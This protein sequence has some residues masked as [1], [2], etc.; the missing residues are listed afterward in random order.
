MFILNPSSTHNDTLS[1]AP[2][3]PLLIHRRSHARYECLQTS[4]RHLF[5]EANR[6]LT[7]ISIYLAISYGSRA[8]E[9]LFSTCT[10][11]SSMREEQT[12]PSGRKPQLTR[13]SRPSQIPA[14]EPPPGSR[15]R[16]VRPSGS[17]QTPLRRRR[18]PPRTDRSFCRLSFCR[19]CPG[20]S[21][22][23]GQLLS[24]A[25]DLPAL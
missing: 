23:W 15:E 4:T 14:R 5:H 19:R 21:G 9:D 10:T 13:S 6:L 3:S 7:R 12:E 2:S 25:T 11:N 18:P 1:P 8:P 24:V 20:C 22:Q 16:G 17:K